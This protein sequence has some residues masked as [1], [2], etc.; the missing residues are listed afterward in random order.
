MRSR[1][2]PHPATACSDPTTL[3]QVYTWGQQ[4]PGPRG[5]SASSH[6]LGELW[7]AAH[8]RGRDRHQ[9]TGAR[10]SNQHPF[11]LDHLVHIRSPSLCHGNFPG[12]PQRSP[13]RGTSSLSCWTEP[14][15]RVSQPCRPSLPRAQCC[16]DPAPAPP[17]V[18]AP[19]QQAQW[20]WGGG[21]LERVWAAARGSAEGTSPDRPGFKSATPWA[22]RSP[23]PSPTCSPVTGKRTVTRGTSAERDLAPGPQQVLTNGL[24]D[25]G[26]EESGR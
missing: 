21:G 13:F 11:M 18:R 23:S 6:S 3:N 25:Q 17:P 22:N 15:I 26:S 16:A 12:F 20:L 5:Q 9:E 14:A 24:H 19:A 7:D 1:L 4:M 8:P 10:Q 2:R